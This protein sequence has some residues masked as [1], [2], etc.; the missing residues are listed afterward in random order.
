MATSMGIKIF[1]DCSVQPDPT[2]EDL[3]EI[4]YLTTKSALHFGIEPRL[5]MLSYS[6]H[7]S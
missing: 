5:A 7:D 1:S 6:T 2:A 3:A 4:A